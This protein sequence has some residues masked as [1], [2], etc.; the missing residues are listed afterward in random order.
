LSGGE[1][2]VAYSFLSNENKYLPKYVEVNYDSVNKTFDSLYSNLN[3]WNKTKFSISRKRQYR[4]YADATSTD[5]L[6]DLEINIIYDTIFTEEQSTRLWDHLWENNNDLTK[7]L[8]GAKE[9]HYIKETYFINH[10]K[11]KLRYIDG[12]SGKTMWSM[13]Y[14]WPSILFGSKKQNP[15]LLIKKKFDKKFPYKLADN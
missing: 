11:Y 6:L 14:R 4:L 13:R 15:V 9:A 3:Y 2:A 12:H 7:E 1:L 5:H 10:I 8:V